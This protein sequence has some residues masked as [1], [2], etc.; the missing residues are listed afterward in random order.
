MSRPSQRA[1]GIIPFVRQRCHGR[2][3]KGL[4]EQVGYDVIGGLAADQDRP[5]RQ[6]LIVCFARLRLRSVRE[7]CSQ[8]RRAEKIKAAVH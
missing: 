2:G 4:H 1:I 7:S 8:G 3:E 6:S 5:K